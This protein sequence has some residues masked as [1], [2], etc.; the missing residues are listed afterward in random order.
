VAWYQCR[1]VIEEYHKGLKTGC[2]IETLQFEQI[3][4]LEPAVGV[5]SALTITLLQ[6]R[7]AARAPNADVRPATDVVSAEYV[8]VLTQRYP[9]RLRGRVSINAFYRH[10]AHL[11]G[12]QNRKGDGFP[13]WIT[14]WRGWMHLEALVLG[15]RLAQRKQRRTCGK[16]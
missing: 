14:L 1:W 7:D 8:E 9:Q 4:R 5:L 15:Y 3:G 2:G 11:G 6:L 16:S 13:G 12:H 10:V